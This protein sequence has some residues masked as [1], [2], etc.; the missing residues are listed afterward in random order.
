MKG[1]FLTQS[2]PGPLPGPAFKKQD[3]PL[4]VGRA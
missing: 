1:P 2:I 4:H 3:T